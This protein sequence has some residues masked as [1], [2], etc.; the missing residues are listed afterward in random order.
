MSDLNNGLVMV[1]GG[2]DPL[3]PGHLLYFKA[4]RAYGWELL[5][6]ID[7]DEFVARKHPVM[8][9]SLERMKLLQALRDVDLVEMGTG[10]DVS[11]ILRDYRPR[12][13]CVGPDHADLDFPEKG[14][15]AE[16]GIDLI[17][18]DHLPKMS[19][20]ELISRVQWSS[21][22]LPVT[23]SLITRK[24]PRGVL[25]V[26]N[27]DGWGLPGGFVEPGEDLEQAF[28]RETMEELG[29]TPQGVYYE[30]SRAGMYHDGREVLA[31]YY[32]GWVH[33]FSPGKESLEVKWST[34][35]EKLTSD[36]DQS[37]YDRELASWR[38]KY[39]P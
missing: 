16:L 11:D 22:N 31:V 27:K 8:L 32:D 35:A 34:S 1:S 7:S 17:V 24:D 37:V 19:S 3:H 6:A 30:E 15:C 9:P 36:C 25:L 23:V 26:R 18:L 14:V 2:F 12:V 28:Y 21:R 13:Y 39:Q 4:A 10:T 5:V 38:R 29:V 20:T 33:T